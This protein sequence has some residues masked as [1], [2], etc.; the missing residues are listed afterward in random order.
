MPDVSVALIRAHEDCGAAR[1]R[2][3]GDHRLRRLARTVAA[4][5]EA[6]PAGLELDGRAAA[7]AGHLRSHGACREQGWPDPSCG[8]SCR[9]SRAGGTWQRRL[10]G[11]RNPLA[12]CQRGHRHTA[13]SGRPQKRFISW[14][15]A[16]C[17]AVVLLVD[18]RILGMAK[19][20]SFAALYRLL[21]LGMMGS[22]QPHHGLPVLR[23][24]T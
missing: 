11:L 14:G 5:L 12:G 18:L 13:G 19:P 20:L 24:E 8:D 6:T 21:P 1:L 16:C 7:V 3:H 23:R 17:S 22:A 2:V 4:S 10:P 9:R 15:S